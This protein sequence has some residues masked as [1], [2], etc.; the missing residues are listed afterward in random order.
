MFARRVSE[1]CRQIEIRLGDISRDADLVTRIDT[2]FET[3][4]II[5]VERSL[6]GFDLV[7][8]RLKTP[9]TKTFPLDVDDLAETAHEWERMW[10]ALD[11]GEPVGVVSTEQQRWNRRVVVWHLYVDAR[12]RR[13]GIARHL[14]D[15]AT[16]S[17]RDRGSLTAWLETSNLNVPGIRAYESLGFELCGFDTSLYEG[18]EADGEI[19]IFLR[20]PLD[21]PRL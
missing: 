19:A 2:S 1:M 12:Y 8:R 10:L 17:A 6:H 21:A 3:D 11:Q 18:T 20:C 7:E 9:V 14:L 5:E 16:E 4:S 13:Q 15:A